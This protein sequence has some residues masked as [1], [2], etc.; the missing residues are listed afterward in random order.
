[1]Q[2]YFGIKTCTRFQCKQTVYH[3]PKITQAYYSQR[4]SLTMDS[5]CIKTNQTSKMSYNWSVIRAA[6]SGKT[7]Q[8]FGLE[9]AIRIS[10]LLLWFLRYETANLLQNFVPGNR[11]PK[12]ARNVSRVSSNPCNLG[13]SIDGFSGIY[14]TPD[15]WAHLSWGLLVSRELPR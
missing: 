10:C 1:M 11:Q 3:Q 4:I 9:T 12:Y 7:Q 8:L 5:Y 2:K 15:V 13:L 14:F 6:V